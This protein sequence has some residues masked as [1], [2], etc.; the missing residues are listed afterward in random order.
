[1]VEGNVKSTH[2]LGR[3]VHNKM[4][5]YVFFLYFIVII[6]NNKIFPCVFSFLIIILP[7]L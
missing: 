6:L 5:Q 1:M 2:I 7:K 4:I 3:Y